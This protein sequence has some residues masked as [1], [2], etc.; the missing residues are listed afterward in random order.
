MCFPTGLD[1]ADLSWNGVIVAYFAQ[2]QLEYAPKI[3]AIV[4]LLSNLTSLYSIIKTLLYHGVNFT[5]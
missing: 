1:V 2:S 5:F 4:T 3:P